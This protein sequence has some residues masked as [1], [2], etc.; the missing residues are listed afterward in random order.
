[1]ILILGNRKEAA[2]YIKYIS[3]SKYSVLMNL[4]EILK[5]KKNAATLEQI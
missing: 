1:M 3:C 2:I 4:A 5:K